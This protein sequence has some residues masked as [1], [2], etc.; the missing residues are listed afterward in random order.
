MPIN[1]LN[2]KIMFGLENDPTQT[3]DKNAS[4]Q[5]CYG[6]PYA[7]FAFG[8]VSVIAY[9]IWAFHLVPGRGPMYISIAVVY[10][11][12]SGIAL[13]RLVNKPRTTFR[14]CLFFAF[15]FF[16]YA[17]LWCLFWFGLKGKFHADLYGSF[18]GLAAMTWL[19]MKVFG[20]KSG[21]LP[22]FAV[23]FTCHTIGYYLGGEAHEFVGGPTG[24]ILWGAFHGLGF[25][26]GLGYL[27]NR[28]QAAE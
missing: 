1:T 21:F 27:L 16:V 13:S 15:S 10:F 9:S 22:L 6:M 14:F 26:V 8:L 2:D 3:A 4:I 12:L 28:C 7:A 25:G 24:R 11:G 18:V 23:L 19:F 20:M 17:I 5:C